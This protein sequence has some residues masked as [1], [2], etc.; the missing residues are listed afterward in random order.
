MNRPPSS[1][2]AI[3][4]GGF[5]VIEGIWGEVSDVV[6]GALTTNRIHATIHILL[7]VLGIWT[8]LRGGA[9]PF[10]IFLGILLIAVGVLRFVPVVGD[11]I[12]QLLAVNHAVAY[13]NIVVGIVSLIVAYG[14]GSRSLDT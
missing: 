2:F 6:F 13:F 1:I 14:F 5:L 11:L 7:G 10:L 4:I 8:G 12:V 3:L 9:R